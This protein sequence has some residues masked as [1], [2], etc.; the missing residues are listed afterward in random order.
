M[1]D[2]ETVDVTEKENLKGH[3]I[4][5]LDLYMH[6]LKCLTFNSFI[7][8]FTYIYKLLSLQV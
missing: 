2:G 8:I 3:G 7:V 6:F 1:Q 5:M 4:L